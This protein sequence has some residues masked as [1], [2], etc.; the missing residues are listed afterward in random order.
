ME[1]Y[2]YTIQYNG[3]G[4]EVVRQMGSLQA[5]ELGAE[6]V[7]NF[8]PTERVVGLLVVALIPDGELE[9]GLP[10]TAEIPRRTG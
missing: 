4:H 2:R 9:R 3:R 10:L 1:W 7:P 5:A 8:D 6:L